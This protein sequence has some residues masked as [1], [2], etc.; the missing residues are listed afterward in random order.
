MFCSIKLLFKYII[1]IHN[2]Y[3]LLIESFIFQLPHPKFES[4][5]L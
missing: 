3:I 4:A 2:I 1:Y 5:P